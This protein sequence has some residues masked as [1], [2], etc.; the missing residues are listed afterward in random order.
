M[1]NSEEYSVLG[2]ILDTT[3]G[4]SS[5]VKSPTMSIKASVAGDSLTFSYTT[6]CH[7]ASDRHLRQQ[8]ESYSEESIQLLN[9]YMKDVKKKF[10]EFAGRALKASQ[11][12]TNDSVEIINTSPYVPTRTAYYRRSVTFEIN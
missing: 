12:D 9:E 7:L 10:K 4:R 6:V 5:T 2:Q 11:I 8:V 3:H 1:L